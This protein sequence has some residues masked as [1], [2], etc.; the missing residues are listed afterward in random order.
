MRCPVCRK[1]ECCPPYDCCIQCEQQK[2]PQCPCCKLHK[3]PINKDKCMRCLN[4]EAK[5]CSRCGR[6][7][8]T[9]PKK[10]FCYHC[11]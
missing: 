10:D 7:N 9:Q 11:I 2:Q 3:C 1:N 4:R 8:L 5:K 6:I